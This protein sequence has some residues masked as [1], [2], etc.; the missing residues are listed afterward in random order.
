MKVTELI[1]KIFWTLFPIPYFTEIENVIDDRNYQSR[2]YRF[3]Q[4]KKIH[5]YRP[6]YARIRRGDCY[7]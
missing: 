2:T 5:K 3:V 4:V 1:Q 6:T 7:I